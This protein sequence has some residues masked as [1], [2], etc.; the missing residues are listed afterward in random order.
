MPACVISGDNRCL[1]SRF[2]GTL[3][4]LSFAAGAVTCNLQGIRC[5]V[6]QTWPLV[7]KDDDCRC[8][9]T[10][11]NLMYTES[12]YKL[13]TWNVGDNGI[14][15]AQKSSFRFEVLLMRMRLRRDVLFTFE[16]LVVSFGG[17][18]TLFV[19][20]NFL[21][22]AMVFFYFGQMVV[23]YLRDWAVSV[24]LKRP[25]SRVHNG[26]RPEKIK[27]QKVKIKTVN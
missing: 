1:V 3:P 22:T 7:V 9:K 21:D 15:F 19:G 6:E 11:N 2:Y 13:S 25:S 8:P 12:S 4:A 23:K 20:Y 17:A 24:A 10:C 27:G 18:I 26:S 16:D 5:L 14:P